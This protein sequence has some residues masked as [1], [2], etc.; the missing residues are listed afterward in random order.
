MNKSAHRLIFDP[1]RGCLMAVAETSRSCGKSGASGTTRNTVMPACP[2]HLPRQF[3]VCFLRNLTTCRAANRVSRDFFTTGLPNF[4]AK[5]NIRARHP[6]PHADSEILK[7]V[8]NLSGCRTTFAS[9]TP[10]ANH[11]APAPARRAWAAAVP[12]QFCSTH[13]TSLR[14]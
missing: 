4:Q 7:M 10:P 8:L 6:P 5:L 12:S 11:P 2:Q 9:N 1:A 14:A 13:S 3:Q